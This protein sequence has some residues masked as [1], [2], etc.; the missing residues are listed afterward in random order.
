MLEIETEVASDKAAWADA[1]AVEK[2]FK[3]LIFA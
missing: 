2:I 1:I 3:S